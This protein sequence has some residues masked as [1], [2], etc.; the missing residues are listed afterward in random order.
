MNLLGLFKMHAKGG[1]YENH[2]QI[3]YIITGD[4]LDPVRTDEPI[5]L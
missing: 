2:S 4:I 1:Y 3:G 5:S